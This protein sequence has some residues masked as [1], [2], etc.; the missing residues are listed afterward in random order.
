NGASSADTG[1]TNTIYASLGNVPKQ[2]FKHL[3][4]GLCQRLA[5]AFSLPYANSACPDTP[6]DSKLIDD[7]TNGYI[8]GSFSGK[9]P[10][11]Y[12]PNG[13]VIYISKHLYNDFQNNALGIKKYIVYASSTNSN[14]STMKTYENI[15]SSYPIEYFGTS[16][17]S[18]SNAVTSNDNKYL[19][20][21]NETRLAAVKLINAG[22][23]SSVNTVSFLK[24]LEKMWSKNK[25]YFNIYV[26]INCKMTDGFE[27]QCGPDT[28]NEDIFLF[29]MYRDGTVIPD[30][31]SGFPIKYLT[32]KILAKDPNDSGGKYKNYSSLV[33]LAYSIKPIV[34]SMCY[35]NMMGS[36]G[37]SYN[38]DH[39]GLC[40][41]GVS[42]TAASA[43]KP[44]S[45][46]LTNIGESKCKIMLNKPSFLLR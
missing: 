43:L 1:I 15:Y 29:R 39:S 14:Y 16:K 6:E 41:Y 38:Y 37:L 22:T 2:Q 36:Y 21:P 8:S 35:A 30:Y 27:K 23:P 20:M 19:N 5:S 24:Y 11:I 3:Q 12:L 4:N 17:F 10:L 46:C 9:T 25:D 26:D 34:F 44:I 18:M 31:R 33:P 42:G 32:S 28:L 13:Q 45:N 7:S 40:S